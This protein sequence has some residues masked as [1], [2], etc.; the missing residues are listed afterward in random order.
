MKDL[1]VKAFESHPM[2]EGISLTNCET[3]TNC[4][5]CT[6]KTYMKDQI[7]STAGRVFDTQDPQKADKAL[8]F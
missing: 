6:P 3:L 1:T 2:F 4:L 7:I 8:F 5:G